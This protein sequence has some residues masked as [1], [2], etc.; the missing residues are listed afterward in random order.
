LVQVAPALPPLGRAPVPAPVAAGEREF[1]GFGEA[2][3]A[4]AVAPDDQGQ[5]GTWPQRQFGLRAD[6]AETAHPDR[7][8]EDPLHIESTPVESTAVESTAVESTR[9]GCGAGPG[10][11]R[12][13][14][15][16]PGTEGVE[17]G[18]FD[19]RCDRGVG[20]DPPGDQGGE[21]RR[22]RRVERSLPTHPGNSPSSP[23]GSAP[24]SG[25]VVESRTKRY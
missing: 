24:V 17:D 20:G 10:T 13:S 25:S 2:G 3:L 7:L 14:A 9:T 19:I 12:G 18:R 8:E 5:A 15:R 1:G 22:S 4:A 6:A 16:S 11:R 21:I 23:A